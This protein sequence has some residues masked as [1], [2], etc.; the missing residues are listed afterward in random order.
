MRPLLAALI[1]AGLHAAPVPAREIGTLPL[2]GQMAFEWIASEPEADGMVTARYR[3]RGGTDGEGGSESLLGGFDLQCSGTMR[4]GAG[5]IL[6]DR[7]ACKLT[8]RFGSQMWMDLQAQPGRWDWHGL[9]AT[10]GDGTG[11]YARLH[12]TARFVR[13]MHLPPDS[14]MLWAYFVG[15]VDWRRD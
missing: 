1:L 5:A 11:P 8:D 15:T 10:L 6:A 9:T 13:I 7:A 3:V 4:F 2:S 12:G 14:M